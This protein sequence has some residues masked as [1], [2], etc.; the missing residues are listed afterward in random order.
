MVELTILGQLARLR[1]GHNLSSRSWFFK[2]LD[3]Q[4]NGCANALFI[5]SYMQTSAERRNL[6]GSIPCPANLTTAKIIRVMAF[7]GWFWNSSTIDG[8][9]APIALRY[10]ARFMR[11]PF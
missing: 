2:Q 8:I 11:Q 7:G 10:S 9:P 4:G 1:I 6:V 3:K 5:F